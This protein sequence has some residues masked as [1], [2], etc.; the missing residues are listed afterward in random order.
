M[1]KKR[2]NIDIGLVTSMADREKNTDAPVSTSKS[3]PRIPIA[4]DVAAT[5]KSRAA[6]L[7][8][9]QHEIKEL[10]GELISHDENLALSGDLVL[11]L[12]PKIIT[13]SAFANRMETSFHDDEF[14]TLKESI[15]NNGQDDPI[16]IRVINNSDSDYKYEI[17]A[18]HRRH[19]ACLELGIEVEA[20]LRPGYSDRDLALRMYREN[21]DRSPT[22]FFE[23]ARWHVNMVLKE[24]YAGD[25]NAYLKD[26]DRSKTTLSKYRAIALVPNEII[27]CF[28]EPKKITLNDAYSI[29][30]LCKDPKRLKSIM[31]RID[32]IKEA[33]NRYGDQNAIKSIL[34]DISGPKAPSQKTPE[35]KVHKDVTGSVFVRQGQDKRAK[36]FKFRPGLDQEFID[37]A[38]DRLDELFKEW[39]SKK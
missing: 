9:A 27:K 23:E 20:L 15:A 18:G 5:A 1:V 33:G 4:E 29:G 34:Q 24:I 28:I 26:F 2:R 37:K 22:S 6:S 39:S 7:E 38:W 8:L 13:A 35:Q 31:T 16:E 32:Q 12:D 30:V 11:K 21:H 25:D 36:V 19:R 10:K 14:R 3:R 17:V